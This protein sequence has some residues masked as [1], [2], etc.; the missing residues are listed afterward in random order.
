[1]P[2]T[3]MSSLK[4]CCTPFHRGKL[5]PKPLNEALPLFGLRQLPGPRMAY[6]EVLDG[7]RDPEDI[8]K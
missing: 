2:Q 3:S 8:N 5:R 6:P 4:V 7:R 1:M